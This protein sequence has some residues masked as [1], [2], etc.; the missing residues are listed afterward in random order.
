MIYIILLILLLALILSIKI[1]RDA[2]HPAVLILTG[3]TI[4]LTIYI[5]TEDFFTI[6]L[7]PFT[8]LLILSFIF[9]FAIA[10]FMA[11][12]FFYSRK[13]H[14]D[15]DLISKVK[16]RRAYFCLMLLT[17]LLASLYIFFRMISYSG[18]SIIDFLASLRRNDIIEGAG[19]V[20]YI[21]TVY[22][23][24]WCF[25]LNLRNTLKKCKLIDHNT[26]FLIMCLVV[27]FA[28]ILNTGKQ[29]IYIFLLSTII[30]LHLKDVKK[31]IFIGVSGLFIL[32]VFMFV[33]RGLERQNGI[34][35]Y[36]LAKYTCSALVAFQEYYINHPLDS[37]GSNAF[38]FFYKLSDVI[39]GTKHIFTT[40]LDFV[41]VGMTTNVY[42]AFSSYVFY[43][44]TLAYTILFVHGFI[45]GAVWRLGNYKVSYRVFY[46]LFSQSVFFMFFHEVFMMNISL[47]LQIIFLSAI[48]SFVFLNRKLSFIK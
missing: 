36:Y 8:C 28:L 7:E 14:F 32:I 41:D 48:I 5:F 15:V 25:V 3:F 26:L 16:L 13:V 22:L 47:W 46:A 21:Q 12:S 38:W 9:T 42:S 6:K 27:M 20:T 37:L 35:F 45:A 10:S 40:H 43:S 33:I 31:L 30:S 23:V 44:I 1:R 2:F 4:S 39:F 29:A 17:T 18:G 11:D 19:W 34:I 24:C